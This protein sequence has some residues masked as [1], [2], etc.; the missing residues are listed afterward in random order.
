MVK[1]LPANGEEAGDAGLASELGRSPGEGNG[2]ALQYPCLKN[3]MDKGAWQSTTVH[4]VSK[5]WT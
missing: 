1:S 5:S 4:G 2:N 3:A